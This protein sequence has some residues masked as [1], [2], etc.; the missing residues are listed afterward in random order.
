MR[1]ELKTT[2]SNEIADRRGMQYYTF[3]YLKP[4]DISEVHNYLNFNVPANDN[5]QRILFFI[6]MIFLLQF[7]LF[8][9]KAYLAA[10]CIILKKLRQVV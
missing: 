7:A 6:E 10:I 3:A 2:S 8:K 1:E 9:I 5:N 4:N